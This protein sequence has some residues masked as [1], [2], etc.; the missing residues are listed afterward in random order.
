MATPLD[1][2]VKLKSQTMYTEI[3]AEIFNQLLRDIHYGLVGEC[4]LE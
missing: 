1:G 2:R 3:K 4:D